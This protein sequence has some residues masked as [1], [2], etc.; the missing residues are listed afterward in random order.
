[1]NLKNKTIVIV[2]ASGGIGSSLAEKLY[3][4]EAKLILVSKS[5]DKL[6]V[7]VK[8][9]GENCTYIRCDLT[10]KD[11]VEKT[12]KELKEKNADISI[13]INV[14]G[15]GIYKNIEDS[16]EED[17]DNS[18]NIT[19]K[20]PFVFIRNLLPIL[21]KTPN[22]VVLNIGSGAG[23]IPMKGRSIYCASKFAL[24]GLILSLAEEY[25]DI[26][27]KF[28]LITLGSTITNFAGMS[29]EEKKRE[30]AKGRAYFPVEWV[31][32]KLVEIIKDD[33]REVE[34]T[35]FPGDYGFGEWKKP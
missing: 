19:V 35:L 32:N 16:N 4:Q 31:S 18:F 27:P 8:R 12:I 17:W 2:G 28:C 14:A 5:Q 25:K 26:A 34:I 21:K 20:G 1:M 22:S 30:H 7:L 23:T 6:T 3:L 29:V 13:L 11:Q 9:F 10:N 15:V 33:N 24:R